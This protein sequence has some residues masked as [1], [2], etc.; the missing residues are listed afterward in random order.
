MLQLTIV[1]TNTNYYKVLY[2]NYYKD[3]YDKESNQLENS[4]TVFSNTYDK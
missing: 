1:L 4:T 2:T 3:I